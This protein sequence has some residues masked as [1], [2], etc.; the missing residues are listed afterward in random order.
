MQLFRRSV[1]CGLI[2]DFFLNKEI[3]LAGWVEKIRDHGG[4]IFIDLRDRTGIIQLVIKPEEQKNIAQIAKDI[5]AEYVIS[6][7]GKVTNRSEPNI[8]I[9]LITGKFEVEVQQ[10]SVVNSCKTLP[11]QIENADNVDDELRLKYRY[12]D[13]RRTKMQNIIKLRHDT[14]FAIREHLNSEE[15]Y[16]IETPLLSKSTPEGARDFLVPSRLQSEKFYALPQSPQIYKQL[17]MASGM[18]KYFQIARCFRDEDFRANRQPE[19]TQL[20]LEMSFVQESDVQDVCEGILSKIW[21]KIFGVSLK[22]PL[23]RYTYDQIFQKFGTDKPDLRFGL[24]I[25]DFTELF[26]RTELKFL[27]SVIDKG[28]KVGAICVPDKNFSRSELSVLEKIAKEKFGASGLLWIKFNEDGKVESPVAKFLPTDFFVE[29]RKKFSSLNVSDTIFIVADEFCKAWECLGRLRLELGKKLN[30]IN[31]N[32]FNFLWVTDFPLLEWGGDQKRWF[33]KHHPFTSPQSGWEKI[34]PAKIKARSYDIICNGEELGGGSIRI[35]D[36]KVQMK[37]FELLG[38]DKKEAKEKFG[39]LLESQELGFPPH[40]GI[41][42]G[43]DRLIMILANVDSIRDVIAFPKTQSGVCPM[44]QTP[45]K[46]DE[47]QL[48]DLHIKLV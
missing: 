6:I 25:N 5:H 23:P 11:Y 20:D 24:E 9:E 13:L 46:V 19:F 4:L 1:Y 37:I 41:A 21:E 12:L 45:S 22:L 7:R 47:K 33:A 43:I 17:L 3:F 36:S 18:E 32:E 42:L 40:G 15:F 39:F 34:D 28:G 27:K 31:K 35:H 29:V 26:E 14:I 44:L 10:L 16:E 8:N 48:K 2:N 38:I 30:L